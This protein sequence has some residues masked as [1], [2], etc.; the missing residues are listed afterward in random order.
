MI[1]RNLNFTGINYGTRDKNHQ[2]K[3]QM[4]Q[5]VDLRRAKRERIKVNP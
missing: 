2:A 4:G 1:S 5:I 3:S